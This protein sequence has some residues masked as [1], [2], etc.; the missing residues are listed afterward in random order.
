MTASEEREQ[1]KEEKRRQRERLSALI[2]KWV[3]FALGRPDHLQGVQVRPLWEDYYRV[4]V[5]VGSDAASA[6]VAHSYFLVIGDDGN[7]VEST[8][9]ITRLY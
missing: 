3:L 1:E 8:P 5:L 2:G 6:R 4:N 7:V 9:E